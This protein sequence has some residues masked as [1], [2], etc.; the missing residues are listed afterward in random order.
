MPWR[1]RTTPAGPARPCCHIICRR[2]YRATSQTADSP[3]HDPAAQPGYAGAC[4]RSDL[5]VR[6]ASL[7]TEGLP[8]AP[9]QTALGTRRCA[10]TPGRIKPKQRTAV[11]AQHHTRLDLATTGTRFYNDAAADHGTTVRHAPIPLAIAAS[12]PPAPAP[13]YIAID[14]F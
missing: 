14:N 12:R 2:H 7:A 10:T 6:A 8:G 11:E 4:L 5:C 3:Q 9:N 13:L 1:C